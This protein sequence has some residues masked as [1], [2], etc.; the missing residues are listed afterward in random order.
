MECARIKEM[1]VIIDKF[2]NELTG[3]SPFLKEE[4]FYTCREKARDL[5]VL[6]SYFNFNEGIFIS[7]YFYNIFD[8]MY[9][10]TRLFKKTQTPEPVKKIVERIN[11]LVNT[12]AGSI[13]LGKDKIWEIYQLMM[14]VRADVTKFK[15]ARAHVEED[16][17]PFL[18]RT[19]G[20]DYWRSS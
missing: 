7:N 10:A 2:K 1:E 3:L 17:F 20:G 13:P 11:N 12:I 18:L 16:I 19:F 8:D 4:N 14:D 9:N 15:L 6:S 5:I